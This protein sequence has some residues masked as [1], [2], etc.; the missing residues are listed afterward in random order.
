MAGGCKFYAVPY[1][2][3]SDGDVEADEERPKVLGDDLEEFILRLIAKT[4]I[5]PHDYT[6]GQMVFI[7]ETYD[8]ERQIDRA[9]AAQSPDLLPESKERK[10]ALTE[11]QERVKKEKSQYKV[12]ASSVKW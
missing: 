4:G 2:A 10:S 3:S 6:F 5:N 12:P 9:C 1:A 7:N 8:T 11:A